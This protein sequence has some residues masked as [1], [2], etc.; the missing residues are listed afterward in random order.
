MT[1]KI[2]QKMLLLSIGVLIVTLVCTLFVLNGYVTDLGKQ[3]LVYESRIVKAGVED[4]GLKYLQEMPATDKRIT[5][6]DKDGDVVYDSAKNPKELENHKDREEIRLAE[7]DGAGFSKRFSKSISEVTIYYA[8]KLK[9]GE[10]LRLAVTKKTLSAMV[11]GIAFGIIGI[12]ALMIIVSLLVSKKLASKIVEPI[13][14]MNLTNPEDFPIYDELDPLVSRIVAQQKMIRQKEKEISNKENELDLIVQ[15]LHEGL[16]IVDK[17]LRILSL[18]DNGVKL[19]SDNSKGLEVKVHDSIL[20]I[21][22]NLEFQDCV[23]KAI[24]GNRQEMELEISGR[25]CYLVVSPT[26]NHK[27]EVAGAVLIILDITERAL[28][29]HQRREFTANVSHELKTPLTSISGYA[30]L[31]KS[32]M[33][34]EEDIPAFS[35]KIYVESQKLIKLVEDILKLSR[36][37]ESFGSSSEETVD[38]KECIDRVCDT[39]SF[40]AKTKGVAIH[41]NNAGLVLKADER[42]ITDVIY[43]LVDNAIKYNHEGGNVWIT[44]FDNDSKKGVM[45]KDD[46]VGIEASEQDRVFERFYR[47]DK[48]RTNNIE[49]TGLG[50]AIVKNGALASGGK[51]SLKSEKNK[52]TEICVFWD[53]NENHLDA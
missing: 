50:L 45:V 11:Q 44:V 4:E 23:E 32:G 51:V 12:F 42:V 22:R 6:I 47:E 43:N 38:V 49:G 2:F 26:F 46:G 40:A 17:G 48:G 29:E 39:L 1:K 9:G 28:G 18:N 5:L 7:K 33:V 8:V 20:A 36:L 3:E 37:D 16:V 24:A 35:E 53:K 13:N 25:F 34:K 10:I 14:S 19:L 21:N 15:N 52:G 27:G 41:R 30:E 31:M